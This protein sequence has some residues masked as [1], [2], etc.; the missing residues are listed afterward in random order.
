MQTYRFQKYS[1]V[2]V[3]SEF[4]D[5]LENM[6]FSESRLDALAFAVALFETGLFTA[7]FDLVAI[8]SIVD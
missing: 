2:F 5:W 6:K 7:W 3:G 8:V 1:K 4:L